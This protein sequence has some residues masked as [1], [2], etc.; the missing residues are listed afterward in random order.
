MG[1]IT[2]GRG[3]DVSLKQVLL[4]DDVSPSIAVDQTARSLVR[5]INKD[6]N[7][8]IYAYYLSASTDVPGKILFEARSLGSP[9]FF[10]SS[11]NSTTGAAFNP[12][13]SP[14]VQISSITTGAT[15]VITTSTPHGLQNKDQVV[16]SSSNSTP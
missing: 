11:N 5:V 16:I 9:Q 4:S 6:T 12:D 8:S 3:E 15:P 14:E 10:I 2:Q 7:S 1:S 13:I